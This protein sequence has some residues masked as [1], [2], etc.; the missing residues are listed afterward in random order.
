MFSIYMYIHAYIIKFCYIEGDSPLVFE[1][2]KVYLAM[3][4]RNDPRV[5]DSVVVTPKNTMVTWLHLR[6]ILNLPV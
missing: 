6:T 4:W 5:E 3:D 2:N 1:G